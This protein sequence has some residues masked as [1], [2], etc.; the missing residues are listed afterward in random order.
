MSNTFEN[1]QLQL[2]LAS[3]WLVKTFKDN[4]EILYYL[5]EILGD[6]INK[7]AIIF[8]NKNIDSY[9]KNLGIDSLELFPY[10]PKYDITIEKLYKSIVKPKYWSIVSAWFTDEH[11]KELSKYT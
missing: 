4:P 8:V 11:K 5:R 6:D 2:Q 10:Y 7:D 3:G 9:S 1:N